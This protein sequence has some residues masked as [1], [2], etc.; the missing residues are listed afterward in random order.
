[1]AAAHFS[2]SAIAFDTC[3]AWL[4]LANLLFL[5]AAA[6]I[7]GLFFTLVPP[8]FHSPHFLHK[9]FLVFL[10]LVN[11]NICDKQVQTSVSL[12]ESQLGPSIYTM[13]R[14]ELLCFHAR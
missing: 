8:P 10:L 6:D 12:C 3:E 4:G 5:W 2:H 14:H 1:M 13:G 9:K 11:I 7:C